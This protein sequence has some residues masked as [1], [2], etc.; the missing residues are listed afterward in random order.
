MARRRKSKKNKPRNSYGKLRFGQRPPGYTYFYSPEQW[1]R[2]KNSPE[3]QAWANGE[4]SG[5]RKRT[6]G[7]FIPDRAKKKK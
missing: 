1:E 4:T 5:W 7:D 2:A 3:F 6:Y